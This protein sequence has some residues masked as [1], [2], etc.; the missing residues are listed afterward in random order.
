[1]KSYLR[2]IT[3]KYMP[4]DTCDDQHFRAMCASYSS[5]GGDLCSSTVI[6]EVAST[7]AMVRAVVSDM[8]KGEFFAVTADHWTSTATE[9]YLATTAHYIDSGFNLKSVTLACTPH[10]GEQTGAETKKAIITAI[11]SFGLTYQSMVCVVT[12]TAPNMT[13]AGRLYDCDFHYCADHVLELTTG[14]KYKIYVHRVLQTLIN[15]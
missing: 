15:T 8:L 3:A 13:L 2:W 5:K 7:S 10:S 14:M 1:M 6:Q 9:A 4:L 12:D 11:T